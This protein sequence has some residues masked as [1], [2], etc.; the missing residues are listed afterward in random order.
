MV[1]K[2]C[3][4]GQSMR[5]YDKPPQVAD[6]SIDFIAF[7]FDFS[8]DWRDCDSIVAQFTQKDTY[9]KV[10]A[11]GACTM[12]TEITAGSCDISL[13][14][15]TAGKP[16]RATVIPL[17]FTVQRSGFVGDGRTPIPP[18]PD[19]YA[20]LLEQFKTSGVTPEDI[21]IAVEK[22]LEDRPIKESDPT[23]P[24]WA[25][26]PEKP[27]YTAKEVGALSEE[28]LPEAV[29]VALA[30]AKASGEFDGQDGEDGRTPVKGED[31]FTEEDR[32]EIAEQ[33]AALVKAP[34]VDPTLTKE[35]FAA[36]AKAAGEAI[37]Q[38]SQVKLITWED[39]D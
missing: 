20:Q 25:K 10:V 5:W 16:H 34:D 26:Q 13:F 36:D 32:D 22:Y 35:G 6:S 18:E 11:N 37:A 2:I 29:A 14:G 17:T 7:Q 23:V 24:E 8:S 4:D 31:Y 9:N 12:P 21:K 33:A 19:L 3:V 39:D 28:T 38:K 30:Q 15:Y 27:K 1:I